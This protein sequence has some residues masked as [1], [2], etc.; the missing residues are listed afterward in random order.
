MFLINPIEMA[1]F[2]AWAAIFIDALVGT[3][4]VVGIYVIHMVSFYGILESCAAVRHLA[5]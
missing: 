1:R 5:T 4:W 2:A 3:V